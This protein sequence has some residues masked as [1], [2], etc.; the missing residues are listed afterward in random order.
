MADLWFPWC[1]TGAADCCDD[2]GPGTAACFA[3]GDC[4]EVPPGGAGGPLQWLARIGTMT[5]ACLGIACTGGG[6]Q[7]LDYVLGCTWRSP[8]ISNCGVADCFAWTLN[9]NPYPGCDPNPVDIRIMQLRFGNVCTGS[10]ILRYDNECAL[11]VSEAT[12]GICFLPPCRCDPPVNLTCNGPI[13]LE[14]TVDL[15]LCSTPAT[16]DVEPVYA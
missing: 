5:G 3:C 6:D 15:G 16:V 9:I 13:T 11:R 10:E 1:S 7:Y 4:Y 14:K 12:G 2:G 8:L